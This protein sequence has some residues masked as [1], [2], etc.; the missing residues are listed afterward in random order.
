M[1]VG[2]IV[3]IANVSRKSITKYLEGSKAMLLYMEKLD[4]WREILKEYRRKYEDI[5]Y[6]VSRLERINQEMK[7]GGSAENYNVLR[8]LHDDFI[9]APAYENLKMVLG[10][11]YPKEELSERAKSILGAKSIILKAKNN[12]DRAVKDRIAEMIGSSHNSLEDDFSIQVQG[13][14]V[15]GKKSVIVGIERRSDLKIEYHSTMK[16]LN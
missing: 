7:I 9:L 5:S 14:E 15:K 16:F 10:L 12:L 2:D 4:S 6:I 8:W 1:A 3:V 13:I 11:K